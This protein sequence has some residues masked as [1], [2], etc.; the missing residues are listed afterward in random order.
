MV[1]LTVGCAGLPRIDPSGRRLLIWPQQNAPATGFAPVAGNVDA[2]PVAAPGSNG[3]CPLCPWSG[4]CPLCDWTRRTTA[5]GV[6]PLAPPP[7]AAAPAGAPDERLTITP[8]RILAPVGSEV[9]LRAGV[10]ADTGYLRTNRRVEWMLGAEG[11]GQFVTVG[12]QGEMDILR[13]PWQRPNKHDNTY[14]VGYTSPF[15][16]CLNRGTADRSDDVQVR[17]GDAWITVSS[18]SEG[19]SY[20]TAYAPESRDWDARRGRAVIYW[21]DAEWRIPPTVNVQPGQAAS[22]ITTVTRKTD[23]API[24]GW[25]V[26]Y[27]VIQ[28][29][30]ARL[31]YQSGQTSVATTNAQGQATM[32]VTPTDD[33]PGTAVLRVSIVK[34]AQSAPMPSPQLE[35]GAGE[36]VVTWT[37]VAQPG[38][39]VTDPGRGVPGGPPPPAPFEPPPRDT[40]PPL[41]P[42]DNRA[43]LLDVYVQRDSDREIRVDDA[44]PVTITIENRGDAPARNI[45]VFDRFE[46][47]L[48][49]VGAAP[50]ESQIQYPAFPDLAPGESDVVRLEFRALSPGRHCHFVRVTM[51]GEQAGATEQ[52]FEIAAPAPAPIASLRVET[53]GEL[54][55]VVGDIYEFRSRVFNTSRV[56]A[57]N[58][59]MEI[60]YSDQL[61]PQQAEDGHV[62][63]PGGLRLKV[64]RLEP[65][66][67]APFYVLFRCDRATA[68]LTPAEVTLFVSADG[69][70]EETATRSL[71]IDA[72]PPSQPSGPTTGPTTGGPAAQAAITGVLDLSN[73]PVR[74]GQPLTLNVA[75]QN[76]GSAPIS[77]VEF[78][79]RFPPQLR[80]RLQRAQSSVPFT[81]NAEGLVFGPIATLQPGAPVRVTIPCDAAQQGQSNLVLQIRA[82]SLPSV[83]EESAVIRVEP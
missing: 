19:A 17:P 21:V 63:I 7:V 42:V 79:V 20:V 70:P 14:A 15:H 5:P 13:F 74:A 46:P 62:P 40:V 6:T 36:C 83:I 16:T 49:A 71:S 52:C 48:T 25:E 57:E 44:I 23:G 38:D 50:G 61:S 64:D 45:L 54:R 51:D 72:A 80:Q 60:R 22:V 77:G 11:T 10:C 37:P 76:N 58:V 31:G 32:Q 39:V 26:R 47:G 75:V 69:V 68:P 53:E 27:E 1:V 29:D 41:G 59:R 30:T 78:F 3:S 12:E 43:P 28:G 56:A 82:P 34:P 4:S 73:N 81:Q 8:D 33:N 66:S 35:L 18:A 24:E 9:I 2:P 55:Q 67:S 65:N